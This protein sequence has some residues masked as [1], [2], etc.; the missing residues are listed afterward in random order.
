MA[1]TLRQ[2][3]QAR[4]APYDF[5]GG[6]RVPGARRTRGQPVQQAPLAQWYRLP[7]HHGTHRLRA[8]VQA[9]DQVKRGDLLADGEVCLHA[10]TS[11][12]IHG[13]FQGPALHPAATSVPTLHLQADG[14]DLQRRTEPPRLP[15]AP[16][17]RALAL[18][19]LLH[20]CGI[21]G[22]GGAGYPAWRKLSKALTQQQSGIHALIINAVES[23]PE[24]CSD[25]ALLRDD[26]DGVIDGAARLCRLLG[27]G[28]CLVALAQDNHDGLNAL[29]GA[30]SR[31]PDGDPAFSLWLVGDKYPAGSERQL[32]QSLTGIQLTG[33]AHPTDIG[34][35]CHNPGTL[36]AMQ[37]AL[38]QGRPLTARLL[39][40]TG[41]AVAEPWHGWVRIG[42]PLQ[43]L[44]TDLGIAWPQGCELLHGCSLTGWPL[45]P[46]A[47]VGKESYGLILRERPAPPTLP[48]IRCS[49]CT[50]ICPAGIDPQTMWQY[51]DPWHPDILDK[52]GLDDCLKCGACDLV[53]PSA[54]PLTARFRWAQTERW[55]AREVDQRAALARQRYERHQQRLAAADAAARQRREAR[56]ERLGKRR[57]EDWLD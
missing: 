55:Q 40:I 9:G 19:Q 29:Q 33:S 57:P 46:D 4:P 3:H 39:T 1:E 5:T 13:I 48:C 49:A 44:L 42:H 24:I 36:H 56:L 20:H 14:Q 8:R 27:I 45:H 17:E 38:T 34:Y 53:C 7:L 51:S 32:I 31:R 16:A 41:P 50:D 2:H 18:Q 43:A 26:A 21:V 23:E 10:P 52:A 47:V 37:R 11:G 6:L 12:T 15:T 28:Q 25:E 54:L 35:L 22:L 30:L